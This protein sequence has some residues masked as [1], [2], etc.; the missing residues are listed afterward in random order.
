M[1]IEDFT[2]LKK[3]V[4]PRKAYS[5][6]YYRPVTGFSIDS[7]SLR[8]GDAFLALKGPH[9]DG[10]RFAASA[11]HKGAS[12]VIASRRI[13]LPKKVPLWIVDDLPAVLA[14]LTRYVRQRSGARVYA[15]TG[16]VGKTTTKEMLAF[17]LESRY[18]V[19]KNIATENNLLGVAKT[20]FGREYEERLVLELGTNAP[21]EIEHLAWMSR[22]DVGVVT[23]IKP[24]HL[25]RLK[26]LEGIAR[27]KTSLFEKI[28][29]IHA[30]LNYDDARLRTASFRPVSWYGSD[31]RCRVWARPADRSLRGAT[32]LINGRFPLTFPF[33]YE[34]FLSNAL[35]A[36]AAA[37]LEKIPLEEA[38]RRMNEFA[39][40]PRGRMDV[41][42]HH[43]V[44]FLHDAY[45]ANPFSCRQVL[46]LIARIPARKI[47]V[48]GDMKEL[49][50]RSV[51][52]HAGLAKPVRDAG[53]TLCVTV[54]SRARALHEAL[55]SSRTCEVYHCAHYQDA[56]ARLRSR[57][58]AGD[59]VVVKGSRSVG[60]ERIF[61]LLG[62]PKTFAA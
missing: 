27:E 2:R 56:A 3:I 28:P 8:P 59:W 42:T 14:A 37:L 19:K 35:A 57:L 21:G 25:E 45:N 1:R 6:Y 30:V 36:I 33:P 16:S 50:E 52:Y 23:W 7:R 48:L 61:P 47:F 29:K 43:G 62:C 44:S 32:Y 11:V 10:H 20:I 54:G 39:G 24:V 55:R 4:K 5:M 58:R 13:S 46:K 38:V 15:V 17:L 9:H 53:I 31:E 51:D 60:L 18:S 40:Y 22:P 12:M 26:S 49:G 34:L 41:R